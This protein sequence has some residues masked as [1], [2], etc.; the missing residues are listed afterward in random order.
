MKS[1]PK[2]LV[3]T[4]SML[5]IFSPIP[6][7]SSQDSNVEFRNQMDDVFRQADGDT[8]FQQIIFGS[9][10]GFATYKLGTFISKP[11]RKEISAIALQIKALEENR[12]KSYLP[13]EANL[14]D[15]EYKARVNLL[16]RRLRSLEGNIAQRMG[17]GTAKFLIRGTQV[18]LVLD[19]GSRIFVLTALERRD[20]GTAP[21]KTLFCSEAGCHTEIYK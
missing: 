14:S 9:I 15:R 6:H 3:V 5:F 21:L 20:P 18:L 13:A 2:I 10:E 19:I 17:R 11:D 7:A 12:H 16:K 8:L 1:S 4:L